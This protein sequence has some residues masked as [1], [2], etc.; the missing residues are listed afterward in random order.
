MLSRTADHLFWMSRY[1]ERA[2]NAAEGGVSPQHS[3]RAQH[4]RGSLPGEEKC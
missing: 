3:Q 1:T 2:A 4:A